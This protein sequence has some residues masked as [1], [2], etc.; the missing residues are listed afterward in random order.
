MSDVGTFRTTIA[1]EHLSQNGE[2][3][4]LPD[5]L[6]DTGSEFTWVPHVVLEDLGIER[7][8]HKRFCLADGSVITRD[9]GYAIVRVAGEAAPDFVIFAE[10]T[11]TILL[12]AHSLEGLNLKIDVVSKKLVDAGPIITAAAA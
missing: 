3:R 4:E 6:V 7:K 2:I 12:G 8:G 11:D 5:T 9:F 1:I 10:P